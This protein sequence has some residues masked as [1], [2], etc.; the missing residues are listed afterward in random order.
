[1]PKSSSKSFSEWLT[2]LC[3]FKN[4]HGHCSVKRNDPDNHHLAMWVNRIRK[5]YRNGLLLDHQIESL[6]DIG[7]E[8]SVI[9]PTLPFDDGIA[10]LESY[11]Q[12]HGNCC[13]PYIYPHNQ[14]L[15]TWVHNQRAQFVRKQSNKY[16]YLSD[17]RIEKL[18]LVGLFDFRSKEAYRSIVDIAQRE[19]AKLMA[20]STPPEPHLEIKSEK[21]PTLI[22]SFLTKPNSDSERKFKHSSSQ[23]KQ[24]VVSERKVKP[25]P[26][27]KKDR[28]TTS[29][30]VSESPKLKPFSVITDENNK[31]LPL[32]KP[33]P[34]KIR[35]PGEVLAVD[36]TDSPGTLLILQVSFFLYFIIEIAPF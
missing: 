31:T 7:F 21:K 22:T 24:N 4:E 3:Q 13:V 9:A 25:S 27:R 18:T 5:K 16:T 17:E 19:E 14:R 11:K 26:A 20:T 2:L 6:K 15:A 23:K 28:T 32:N 30:S 8:W 35:K 29:A 12:K 10:F 1:M 36:L 33:P 34:T